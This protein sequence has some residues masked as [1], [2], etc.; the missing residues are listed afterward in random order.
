MNRDSI[1]VRLLDACVQ[2]LQYQG[3]SKMYIDAVK[4]GEAGFQSIGLSF[5]FLYCVFLDTSETHV[6]CVI[7]FQK[8]ATY[9]EV[10]KS[11]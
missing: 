8:W 9:R 4:G 3:M 1:M 2:A 10:W 11:V 7:G 6:D 5:L